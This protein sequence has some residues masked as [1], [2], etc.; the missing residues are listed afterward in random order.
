MSSRRWWQRRDLEPDPP[1]P[2]PEH[3]GRAV[4]LAPDEYGNLQ[5]KVIRTAPDAASQWDARA[6]SDKP[7]G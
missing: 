7:P 4:I 2:P 6:W 5:P 3:T 1:A